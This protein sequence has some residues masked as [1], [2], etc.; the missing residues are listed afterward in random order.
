LVLDKYV[1]TKAF[2]SEPVIEIYDGDD[3][4]NGNGNGNKSHKTGN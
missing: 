3:E 2:E 4:S 1:V